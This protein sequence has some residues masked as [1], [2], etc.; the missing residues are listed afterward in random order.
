MHAAK[1]VER[2]EFT[3][4]LHTEDERENVFRIAKQIANKNKDVVAVEA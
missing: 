4:K 3:K 1:E 2:K